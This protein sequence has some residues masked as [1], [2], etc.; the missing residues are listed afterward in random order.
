VAYVPARIKAHWNR[1]AALPCIACGRHGVQIA[2]QHGPSLRER[3]PRFLK[4][5]GKKMRWQDWLVL[6]LCP[7]CHAVCDNSPPAFA[8]LRGTP[9][10]LLDELCVMLMVDVWGLALKEMK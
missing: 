1:V 9:A 10:V 7:G 6:P 3:N 4:P 5:K 8:A 2:H